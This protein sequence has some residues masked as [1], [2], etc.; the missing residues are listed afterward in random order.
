MEALFIFAVTLFISLG[1]TQEIVI[2]AGEYVIEKGSEAYDA[3]KELITGTET[4]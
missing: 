4:E 1:V 2:P 3:G